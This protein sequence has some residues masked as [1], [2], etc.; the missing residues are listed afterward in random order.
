M[1]PCNLT[2]PL[3][4]T[5]TALAFTGI[6]SLKHLS[7]HQHHQLRNTEVYDVGVAM[8]TFSPVG[9]RSTNGVCVR[10]CVIACVCV[11]VQ[12]ELEVFTVLAYPHIG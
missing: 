11:C 5:G 10:A 1:D 6:H 8:S 2:P 7:W 4:S 12:N 3:H 9:L